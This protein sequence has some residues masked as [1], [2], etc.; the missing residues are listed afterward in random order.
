MFAPPPISAVGYHPPQQF[1]VTLPMRTQGTIIKWKDEKGFGFA[2]PEEGGRDIFIHRNAFLKGT[3]QPKVGDIVTFEVFSTLEGK[4]WGESVL[5]K[6]Q[7]DPRKNG[8]VVDI[9]FITL[10][11]MFLAAISGLVSLQLLP[12]PLLAFYVSVSLLTFLVYRFDKQ[13]AQFNDWR[14]S[15]L[16]LH[17]LSLCGGW[18]GA[19]VAQRVFHHKSK[20]RSFQAALS[21]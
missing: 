19:L 21:G 12:W 13:A 11:V 8:V 16:R 3:R 1:A 14:T 7:R 5:F 15:E 17:L 4:T 20:K 6:G 9:V 18:P 2:A 10:A